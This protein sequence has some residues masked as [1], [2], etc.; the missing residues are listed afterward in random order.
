VTAV[1][2]MNQCAEMTSSARGRGN[3]LPNSR[4]PLVKPFS[5]SVFIGLPWPMKTAGILLMRQLPYWM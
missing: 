2:P 3:W 4:H 5:S 1:A